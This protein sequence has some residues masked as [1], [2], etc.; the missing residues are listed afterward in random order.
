[1][2]QIALTAKVPDHLPSVQADADRVAQV[3]RNLLVNAVRH[4][5]SGGSV[6]V[7]A[8][9][10]N[11]FVR[12]DV[13]DTGGGID[14]EDLPH[15]FE[16]FWTAD[17]A[18]VRDKRLVGGTGLGLSVAQSLVKAQGGDIWAASAPGQGSTFSF[19]LPVSHNSR[20]GSIG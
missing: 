20:N 4:T 10:A 5:P 8:T 3:L 13:A 15:L 12:I 16:R 2:Q 7:S 14:P 19:T 18:R 9:A 1:M 6:T 11:G 17:R